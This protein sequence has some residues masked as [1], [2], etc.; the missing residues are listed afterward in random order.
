LHAV[1]D[2]PAIGAVGPTTNRSGT[3]AEVT[4]AYRTYG[5]L[6]ALAAARA[7][8]RAGELADVDMLAMFCTALRRETITRIGPLDDGFG[9]GLFE[10]DDYARRL[11]AAGLRLCVAL[12]AFVHH[13][14][15]ATIGRL[16]PTGEYAELFERNR[17]RFEARWAETWTPHRRA[18]RTLE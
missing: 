5:E 14:G 3:D 13:F 12:D 15:E 16:V 18:A 7:E 6:R 10:D 1:L 9:L 8:A 11:H 2:D 17:Q 4:T